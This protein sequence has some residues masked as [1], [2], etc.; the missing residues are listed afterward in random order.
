MLFAFVY[1]KWFIQSGL[2]YPT[3]HVEPWKWGFTRTRKWR[4][5]RESIVRDSPELLPACYRLIRLTTRQIRPNDNSTG[6]SSTRKVNQLIWRIPFRNSHL[7][8]MQCVMHSST[9][10][11]SF[12]TLK[13]SFLYMQCNI[14][15]R[16]LCNQYRNI[17]F[18]LFVLQ[19]QIFTKIPMRN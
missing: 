17:L 11:I 18:V 1:R 6:S 19:L 16:W 2:V 9:H 7:T 15:I 8:G 10:L 4:T 12:S 13:F 3:Q 14:Q 5:T